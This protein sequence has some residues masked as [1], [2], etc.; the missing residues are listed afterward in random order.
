[1]RKYILAILFLA[2]CPL[3]VAQQVL[4]NDSVIKLVKAGLSDDLIVSTII[5][6]AG[7]YDSSAEGIIALKT[8]GA[9]DKVVAAIVAKANAPA[10]VAAPLVVP[11][12]PVAAVPAAPAAAE[13]DDPKGPHDPGIYIYVGRKMIHLGSTAYT[14]RNDQSWLL[15]G[16][17]APQKFVAV[18][19]SPSAIV[20]ISDHS[21]EFYFYAAGVGNPSPNDFVLV[22][23]ETK[24]NN[25]ETPI[26]K[27]MHRKDNIA[28]TATKISSATYKVALDAPLQ[29]GEYGFISAAPAPFNRKSELILFDFGV[30]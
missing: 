11:P 1:M 3:L 17:L 7:N 6:S 2:I 18:V 16:P 28:L 19:D 12:A 14:V 30:K 5:A 15:S 27:D 24:S 26:R 25:R 22:R 4:N 23:L 29:T 9:S 8:A 13:S 21:A 20:Q 10:P